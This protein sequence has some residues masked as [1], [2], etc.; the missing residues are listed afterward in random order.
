MGQRMP[1]HQFPSGI[2]LLVRASSEQQYCSSKRHLE[3]RLEPLHLDPVGSFESNLLDIRT[4]SEIR[5]CGKSVLARLTN[6]A[7]TT[8]KQEGR[9]RD[10]GM[11][12]APQDTL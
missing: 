1:L 9:D 2:A 7:I 4:G 3:R 12:S 8:R 5:H 11:S 6:L 10:K